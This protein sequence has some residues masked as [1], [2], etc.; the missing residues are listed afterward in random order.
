MEKTV[1]SGLTA[2]CRLAVWPTS[3]SPFLANATTD[4]TRRPPSAVVITTG[5]PP[6]NTATTEFVVPKSI[7]TTLP[8]LYILLL[9]PQIARKPRSLRDAR[10]YDRIAYPVYKSD[11]R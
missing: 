10:F 1:F 5:S 9:H 11:I 6:S 7:P 8:I 2:A 4:G 3:R